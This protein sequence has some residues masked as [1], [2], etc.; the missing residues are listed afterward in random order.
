M[1]SCWKRD[2]GVWFNIFIILT[3]L[4]NDRSPRGVVTSPGWCSSRPHREVQ[5]VRMPDNIPHTTETKGR[6]LKRSD[7]CFQGL[8]YHRSIKIG[9]KSHFTPK[10]A[11]SLSRGLIWF[12]L[13]YV[14]GTGVR[15]FF[16]RRGLNISF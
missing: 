4:E 14:Q 13:F 12:M 11:R 15:D 16:F 3:M 6:S 9:P 10:N 7:H 5:A 1:K 2:L 8:T